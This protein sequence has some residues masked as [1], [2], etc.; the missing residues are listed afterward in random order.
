VIALSM[1]DDD[2]IARAIQKAGAEAFVSKTA[3]STELLRAIFGLPQHR[4]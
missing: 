4:G 2:N 1:V 3:S